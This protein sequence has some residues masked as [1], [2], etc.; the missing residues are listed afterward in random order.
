M[1]A[2][3]LRFSPLGSQR[4]NFDFSV[5][6][7]N[8]QE[9]FGTNGNCNADEGGVKRM[10]KLLHMVFMLTGGVENL[11]VKVYFERLGWSGHVSMGR[12][13]EHNN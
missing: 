7:I 1:S 13:K 8:L 2:S 6:E 9:S 5:M 10:T 11:L 3:S 4:R 12:D